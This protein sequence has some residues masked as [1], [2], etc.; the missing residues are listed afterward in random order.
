MR[1]S[2]AGSARGIREY[3]CRDGGQ[4]ERRPERRE[5]VCRDAFAHRVRAE[6]RVQ[7]RT[8]TYLASD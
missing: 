5:A 6:G 4:G 3:E 7:V 1:S 8:G 2:D